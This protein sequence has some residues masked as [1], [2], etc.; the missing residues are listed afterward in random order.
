M[1]SNAHVP[2]LLGPVLD[3]LNLQPDGCYVDATFGRGGHSREILRQL[4]DS[5]FRQIAHF[6]EIDG[7]LS[8]ADPGTDPFAFFI[9][10][11]LE[12]VLRQL[13]GLVRTA[14]AGR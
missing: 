9:G 12:S 10:I 2:V 7:P 8:P 14:P 4:G 11:N 5:L 6:G 13:L 1:S 3:G